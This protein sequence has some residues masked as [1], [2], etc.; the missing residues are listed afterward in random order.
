MKRR[1]TIFFVG[2]FFGVYGMEEPSYRWLEIVTMLDGKFSEDLSFKHKNSPDFLRTPLYEKWRSELVRIGYR[3]LIG[4]LELLFNNAQ[5]TITIHRIL[6]TSRS[7]FFKML[8]EKYQSS[9]PAEQVLIF[10]RDFSTYEYHEDG[11]QRK[12]FLSDQR[13]CKFSVSGI[14]ESKK[15]TPFGWFMTGLASLA[16]YKFLTLTYFNLPQDN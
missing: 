12:H 7:S 16:C 3:S 11:P 1:V 13:V 6:V 10:Y 4:D 15:L 9:F 8:S 5:G 14:V 2:C